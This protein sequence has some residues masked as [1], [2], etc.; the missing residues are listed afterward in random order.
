MGAARR[1]PYSLVP[2]YT[3]ISYGRGLRRTPLF[4][5]YII[6]ILGFLGKNDSRQRFILRE[7]DR[8][9]MV[10]PGGF[11]PPT[12]GSLPAVHSPDLFHPLRGS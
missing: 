11:E 8:G 2:G 12:Y 6:Q 5:R 4:S 1:I 3:G 10:G 7:N 9:E